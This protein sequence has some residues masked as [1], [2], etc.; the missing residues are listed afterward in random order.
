VLQQKYNP[1]I[2][3]QITKLEGNEL[4]D[5]MVYCSFSYYTLVVSS[6]QEI[7]AMIFNK[8]QLYKKENVRPE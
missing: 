5:F 7:E 1:D 2:V 8:F 3:K 6:K 4:E